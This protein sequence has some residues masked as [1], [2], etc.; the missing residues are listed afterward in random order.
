M[1]PSCIFQAA[2]FR[3]GYIANEVAMA[4]VY[5]PKLDLTRTVWVYTPRGGEFGLREDVN[6]RPCAGFTFPNPP[7]SA[8]R[9]RSGLAMPLV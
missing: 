5:S 3:E 7:K 4:A 1:S 9:S 6:G 2:L 8:D